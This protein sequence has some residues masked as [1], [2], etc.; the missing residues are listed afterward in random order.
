MSALL[1]TKG[2]LQALLTRIIIKAHSLRE[3]QTLGIR[4]KALAPDQKHLP[5]TVQRLESQKWHGSAAAA[6]GMR[7][8]YETVMHGIMKFCIAAL[9]EEAPKA[10]AL[11]ACC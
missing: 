5:K 4:S 7:S 3:V 11:F 6:Q 9:R 1:L 8:F 10:L 2:M